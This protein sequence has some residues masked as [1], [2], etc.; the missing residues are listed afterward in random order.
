MGILRSQGRVIVRYLGAGPALDAY[1]HSSLAALW[2]V[3]K[4]AREGRFAQ[5]G[6]LQAL[7]I[8]RS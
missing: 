7:A 1:Q 5:Q 2:E 6:D 4:R 8:A 3:Q